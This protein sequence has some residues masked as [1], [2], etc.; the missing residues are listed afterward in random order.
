[1]L[2]LVLFFVSLCML[3]WILYFAVL[4]YPLCV[5]GLGFFQVI[6]TCWSM[7]KST[8]S[9]CRQPMPARSSQC[10]GWSWAERWTWTAPRQAIVQQS[11]S[12]PSLSM[13]ASCIGQWLEVTLHF[14]WLY[15]QS[16]LQCAVCSKLK[17]KAK[18]VKTLWKELCDVS[19]SEHIIPQY[20]I[21][22]FPVSIY[23]S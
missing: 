8:H 3:N 12:K 2:G 19:H 23:Y 13:G 6:C 11:P 16:A 14:N 4:W 7:A 15:C 9:L 22:S 1:M 5:L 17:G 21:E 10:P 18:W 20:F